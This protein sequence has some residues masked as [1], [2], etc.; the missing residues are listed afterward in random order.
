MKREI[1]FRA[2]DSENES[3]IT[4]GMLSN[5]EIV[6]RYENLMQYTGL[7]DKN[8]VEL[9]EGDVVNCVFSEP[10]K[11]EVKYEVFFDEEEAMFKLRNDNGYCMLTHRTIELEIIGNIHK[12]TQL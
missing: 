1:K 4:Y 6:D 5:G 7:L 12:S 11:E 8:S 9:F 10:K 3:M 2:W